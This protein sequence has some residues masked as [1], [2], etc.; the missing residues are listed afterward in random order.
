MRNHKGSIRGYK[1]SSKAWY[2]LP[3][4]QIDVYFGMYDPEGGTTGEM[5]MK[6]HDLGDE[7][8]CAR[9][10]SFEDSWSALSL[11]TD[12]IQK[13]GERDSQSIQEEEFCKILDECGF[14]DLT[15]YEIT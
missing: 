12:L 14:E 15:K 5:K 11:F 10:E 8:P 4:E 1:R 2:A 9:L 6:W 13:L 3:N 7:K